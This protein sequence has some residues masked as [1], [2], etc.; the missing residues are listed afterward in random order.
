MVGASDG[1]LTQHRELRSCVGKHTVDNMCDYF[2]S[3]LL[4]LIYLLLILL[5]LPWLVWQSLRKG[6]YREGYGAKLLGL[7]PRR[8]ADADPAARVSPVRRASCARH[9]AHD[10]RCSVTARASDAGSSPSAC[11]DST[12]SSTWLKAPF[13][14]R[15][16]APR[17]AAG[18]G[19]SASRRCR[20]SSSSAERC[21]CR[22]WSPCSP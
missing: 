16:C 15:P 3:Y 13:P 8:A 1:C 4:N 19:R 10:A 6:K 7:V 11:C 12:S 5:S 21:P 18:C 14:L 9:A 2:V 20:P 22:R 17:A